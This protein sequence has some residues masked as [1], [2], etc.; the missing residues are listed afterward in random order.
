VPRVV[1][2]GVTHAFLALLILSSMITYLTPFLGWLLGQREAL[3]EEHVGG[4]WHLLLDSGLHP[5]PT[6][7]PSGPMTVPAF[8]GTWGLVGEEGSPVP[9]G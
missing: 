1:S 3:P 9:V 4:Q 8:H 6:T 5:D 7:V 2:S